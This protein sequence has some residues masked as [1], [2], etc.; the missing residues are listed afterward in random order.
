MV[1]LVRMSVVP[2]LPSPDI[3]PA[4]AE[5][6]LA[7]GRETVK[8]LGDTVASPAG[9]HTLPCSNDPTSKT[10]CGKYLTGDSLKLVRM[11]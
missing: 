4:E 8:E 2:T 5:Y 10:T 11:I 9:W 1:H 6:P 7:Y 3:L